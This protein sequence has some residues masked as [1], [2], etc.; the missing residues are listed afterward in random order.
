MSNISKVGP[1]IHNRFVNLKNIRLL[2]VTFVS[3]KRNLDL[4]RV[5]E[6]KFNR[7]DNDKFAY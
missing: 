6:M 5:N 4:V 7:L 1:L 3:G 2:N